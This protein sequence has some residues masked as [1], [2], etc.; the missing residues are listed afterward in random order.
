MQ[1]CDVLQP[2]ESNALGAFAMDTSSIQTYSSSDRLKAATSTDHDNP[3]HSL[4]SFEHSRILSSPP[5][6]DPSSSSMVDFP[7]A[8]PPPS[9]RAA[10]CHTAG[11]SASLS[12]SNSESMVEPDTCEY[13]LETPPVTA[14]SFEP[15]SSVPSTPMHVPSTPPS[16]E[17][18]PLTT[19]HSRAIDSLKSANVTNL[20]FSS[21][22]HIRSPRSK[23]SR[24]AHNGSHSSYANSSRIDNSGKGGLN[25]YDS[26]EVS[27]GSKQVP[28]HSSSAS[29]SNDRNWANESNNGNSDRTSD[30]N[31]H[32]NNNN[33]NHGNSNSKNDINGRNSFSSRTRSTHDSYNG[34][35]W[36]IRTSS[37]YNWAF[38]TENLR[39]PKLL[40]TGILPSFATFRRMSTVADK[41]AAAAA[42]PIKYSKDGHVIGIT[43][44]RLIILLTSPEQ[45]DYN[46]LSDFFLSYRQFMSESDVLRLLASRY[47]WALNRA[48]DIGRA[49]RFRTFV[50]LRHWILNYFADDFVPSLPLR[51]AF[52]A[53]I[54]EFTSYGKV[55]SSSGDRRLIGEIKRCW[56]R[57][58]SL[59]WDMPAGTYSYTALMLSADRCFDEILH[60]GGP[61]GSRKLISMGAI[62]TSP[63]QQT[64]AH[65]V[66]DAENSTSP[67][68]PNTLPPKK[69]DF[70]QLKSSQK[71]VQDLQS[72]VG[73]LPLSLLN[74]S[75]L[76]CTPQDQCRV[77][78][79]SHAHSLTG[80][81]GSLLSTSSKD[82]SAD[83]HCDKQQPSKRQ[84]S[85]LTTEES[86]PSKP[87]FGAL[88]RGKGIV[89]EPGDDQAIVD[90]VLSSSPVLNSEESPDVAE[91]SEINNDSPSESHRKVR[92]IKDW[93]KK[94]FK[95]GSS[96][97]VARNSTEEGV[98]YETHNKYCETIKVGV[99]IDIL[100]ASV[101]DSYK[102]LK[103]D[104]SQEQMDTIDPVDAQSQ[105]GYESNEEFDDD[106]ADLIDEYMEE[107]DQ[108]AAIVSNPKTPTDYHSQETCLGTAINTAIRYSDT[109]SSQG[110]LLSDSMHHERLHL[111][112][113]RLSY[114]ESSN[115]YLVQHLGLNEFS[116]SQ[117][118]S[119]IHDIGDMPR[120]SAILLSH[121]PE[122]RPSDSES[123]ATSS[124]PEISCSNSPGVGSNVLGIRSL[125]RLS[126]KRDLKFM[127]R[128][129]AN[130][131]WTSS[132]SST[133]SFGDGM[134]SRFS[135]STVQDDVAISEA[136]QSGD[137]SQIKRQS[138]IHLALPGLTDE[139]IEELAKLANIPDDE[140]D[141]GS[142]AITHALMKLEGVKVKEHNFSEDYMKH[143]KGES[144]D[145][146]DM[147]SVPFESPRSPGSEHHHSQVGDSFENQVHLPEA[148]WISNANINQKDANN[149]SLDQSELQSLSDLYADQDAVELFTTPSEW[150]V[151]GNQ[152]I[153]QDEPTR[154]SSGD[155]SNNGDYENDN[156]DACSNADSLASSTISLSIHLP[157]ILRYRSVD[158]AE[159]FTL[160]DRDILSEVDW[161]EL[162][163]LRWQQDVALVQDW[164][165]FITTRSVRGVELIITRF[166]LMTSWVTSEILLTR[167]LE[168]RVKTITKFIHI[169]TH[170]LTMQNYLAFMEFTLA[171]ASSTVQRLTTTWQSVPQREREIFD[172]LVE[173]AS[174]LKN[175]KNLRSLMK[176]VDVNKGCIPFIGLY[177]SDLTFN[178]QKSAYY[179][180]PEDETNSNDSLFS[181][182]T[183]QIF[184]LKGQDP[185]SITA[186]VNFERFR[187]SASIIKNLLFHVD[188]SKAY[189][190]NIKA[191]PEILARCL[192]V[193]CL[194]D[195]EI[196]EC[197]RLME[198][199]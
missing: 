13:K 45:I 18:P 111:P 95:V 199:P 126:G 172:S 91:M 141:I 192:Y 53:I 2:S 86:E 80:S 101:V 62:H 177:L 179:E 143:I 42:V 46:I 25:L 38:P 181:I 133:S 68:T 149:I 139:I 144:S 191:I 75:T 105:P 171:L 44:A 17:R 92:K 51:R 183:N 94:V 36:P 170:V 187:V 37:S 104:R 138:G 119:T 78:S 33:N 89:T 175:F 69:A 160:L 112:R 167:R 134:V 146:N 59:Y 185:M 8:D 124:V 5:P 84:Q 174:P 1:N 82:V 164:F 4:P 108:D 157:F 22:L 189:D 123:S 166:N 121:F 151:A 87:R 19:P 103:E 29:Y 34:K 156:T 54:N 30:L 65:R 28:D 182:D 163:E 145:N 27:N 35:T 70:Q 12:A 188:S 109:E 176:N 100:A 79:L 90:L 31:K 41:D 186:L 93:S 114:G 81:N 113:T 169:A 24:L 107:E 153:T 159:Q 132:I 76:P 9:S 64:V 129:L 168:E 20:S 96:F 180:R 120:S 43:P 7:D 161:K 190:K 26:G 127:R 155:G 55:R 47:K 48:D 136:N 106:L 56:I 195:D 16:S 15:M 131:K 197:M 116:M 162:I 165:S 130:F 60:P 135:I 71:S 150:N 98:E 77:S 74:E 158:L 10:A 128:S 32:S 99:R 67:Q 83:V 122:L 117:S 118:P 14:S 72:T 23:L 73:L 85:K 110:S 63:R 115:Q 196:E 193:S 184:C 40:S 198:E 57:V 125:R 137:Q 21:P 147:S 97:E 50:C 39:T 88:I 11:S 49:V 194:D 142:N 6:P 102:Q 154:E 148:E 66:D 140:E 173:L 152:L 3:Y 178:A 52:V 58:S 61:V